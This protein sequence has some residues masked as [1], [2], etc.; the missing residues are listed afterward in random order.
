MIGRARA[1]RATV[2]LVVA[3]VASGAGYA[4]TFAAFSSDTGNT[5]NSYA[6]G[7]VFLT[8][9]GGAG[10]F[11]GSTAAEPGADSG[12]CVTVTYGG[13]LPA[14]VRLYVSTTGNIAPY[15]TVKI[16]RG[17]G[18]AGFPSCTGFTAD[19]DDYAGLGAG[20]VYDGMVAALPTSGPTGLLDP[21]AGDPET[22]T[23]GES[24]SYRYEVTVSSDTAGQNR[25]GTVRFGFQA[26]NT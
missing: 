3:L 13:S 2:G 9:N 5:D 4:T 16:T 6:A 8:G 25:S 1:A 17:S 21:T 7:T 26:S 20:V 23:T 11:S 10:S 12:G 24:H 15:L 22:W 14:H 19:A 18:S